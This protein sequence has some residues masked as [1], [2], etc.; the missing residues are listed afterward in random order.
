MTKNNRLKVIAAIVLFAGAGALAYRALHQPAPISGKMKLVCV[1]TG[2]VFNL[3][4][5]KIA[6][7]PAVNPSTGEATLVPCYEENGEV[8]IISRYADLLEQLREKNKY[9]DAQ[10]GKVVRNP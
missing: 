10:T 7:Y 4:R 1:A 9:V 5:E 6:S 3:S 8:Y 2:Q